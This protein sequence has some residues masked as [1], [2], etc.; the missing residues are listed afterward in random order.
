MEFDAETYNNQDKEDNE[1]QSY[2][3]PKFDRAIPIVCLEW[4]IWKSIC[5]F[6]VLSRTLSVG[7]FQK[8]QENKFL[9]VQLNF[10][11]YFLW[12]SDNIW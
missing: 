9:C 3:T 6:D 8:G 10:Q 1:K 11:N 4:D 5:V 7:D 2:C 12:V